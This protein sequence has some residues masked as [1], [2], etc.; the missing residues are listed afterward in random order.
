MATQKIQ[1]AD[2]P[3]LDTVKDKVDS[4]AIDIPQVISQQAASI[5]RNVMNTSDTVIQMPYSGDIAVGDIVRYNANTDEI[6][7]STYMSDDGL[8]SLFDSSHNGDYDAVIKNP[9]YPYIYYGVKVKPSG[10]EAKSTVSF[11]LIN[12]N[13]EK[14]NTFSFEIDTFSNGSAYATTFNSLIYNTGIDGI[15]TLV[16]YHDYV[17]SGSY[18]YTSVNILTFNISTENSVS[19]I[20]NLK[21]Y[22]RN[23]YSSDANYNIYSFLTDRYILENISS[24]YEISATGK[25]SEK[26]SITKTDTGN[27]TYSPSTINKFTIYYE[28]GKTYRAWTSHTDSDDSTTY[29]NYDIVFNEDMSLTYTNTDTYSSH[30]RPYFTQKIY[31]LN[32]KDSIGI[33]RYYDSSNSTYYCYFN[34]GTIDYYLVKSSSLISISKPLFLNNIKIDSTTISDDIIAYL[35]NSTISAYKISNNIVSSFTLPSSVQT[36]I[37]S[38]NFITQHY[39]ANSLFMIG[40][41]TCRIQ[42]TTGTPTDLIYGICK[43]VDSNSGIANIAM[44]GICKINKNGS[45]GLE[46][47]NLGIYVTKNYINLTEVMGGNET[48]K[49]L[50]ASDNLLK[51]VDCSEISLGGDSSSHVNLFSFIPKFSG[52]IKINISATARYST[53]VYFNGQLI[54]TLQGNSNNSYSAT[55][56]VILTVKSNISYTVTAQ[57]GFTVCKINTLELYADILDYN[58]DEILL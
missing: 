54:S 57:S 21:L 58:P 45:K 10:T 34:K 48:N 5:S 6:Y 2:K 24:Y 31:Q 29:Y 51:T 35:V 1:I 23:N 27:A 13:M 30:E 38:S 33:Y 7:S 16:T 41:D 4:L 56:S 55:A 8:V 15:L 26:K 36:L 46:L 17:R 18:Y 9:K 39:L 22:D 49:Y 20:D 52:T 19:F 3:T 43:S 32:S 53:R 47:P 12:T 44:S 25:I 11:D 50:K 37:N 40:S 28:F 42:Y 14:I